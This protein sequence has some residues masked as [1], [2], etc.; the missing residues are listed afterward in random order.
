MKWK[1]LSILFSIPILLIYIRSLMP[2]LS[3]TLFGRGVTSL[4]FLIPVALFIDHVLIVRFLSPVERFLRAK[5]NPSDDKKPIRDLAFSA[6]AASTQIPWRL[7]AL[8]LVFWL[9]VA[10]GMIL[11]VALEFRI[12]LDDA[13]RV[14][15]AIMSASG[16]A[17]MFQFFQYKKVFSGIGQAIL[18]AL[19]GEMPNLNESGQ[20]ISIA[21]TLLI[22]FLT[23]TSLSLSILSM[24]N[25]AW[26]E[27]ALQG[28]F[29]E[30][31]EESIDRLAQ[32][33]LADAGA[34]GDW[35]SVRRKIQKPPHSLGTLLISPGG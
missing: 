16:L 1:L 29:A 34:H 10:V 30:T 9:I 15:L 3:D 12:P 4:V 24:A 7:A 28:L 25:Y 32:E 5:E 26:S 18:E 17:T 31:Q 6:L 22:S 19:P 21:T 27:N 14:I 20:R 8:S 11:V 23:L 2:Y 33:A 35:D 13:L